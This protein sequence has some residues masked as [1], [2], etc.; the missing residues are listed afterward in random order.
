MGDSDGSV[1]V[2]HGT[3][4]KIVIKF[5]A[6]RNLALSHSFA[7]MGVLSNEEEIVIPV[8]VFR[9]NADMAPVAVPPASHTIHDARL[10]TSVAAPQKSKTTPTTE[11]NSHL[12]YGAYQVPGILVD[13][14]IKVPVT[15]QF[16]NLAN[17]QV[18]NAEMLPD[19]EED[20]EDARLERE[21]EKQETHKTYV[22]AEVVDSAKWCGVARKVWIILLIV[23]VVIVGIVVGITMPPKSPDPTMSPT[24][25]PT[26]TPTMVPMSEVLFRK[27]EPQIIRNDADRSQ[28]EDSTTPQA[29]A[30][31][32]LSTDPYSLSKNRATSEIL[33]RYVLVLLYYSTNGPN[34][35]LEDL[36][37]REESPVCDWNNRMNYPG[38]VDAR[39]I[40]CTRN[41]TV[42]R[43]RLNSVGLTGT[44][45]WELS[46]LGDLVDLVLSSN[47]LRESLPSDF[48]NLSNLKIFSTWG[49]SLTGSLPINLP[50]SLEFLEFSLNSMG[51]TIPSE[52]GN[53]LINLTSLGFF[54]NDLGGPIPSELGLL[55]AMEYLSTFDNK[56]TG[57]LPSELGK[58]TRLRVLHVDT[59]GFTGSLPSELGQLTAL[60][61]LHILDNGFKGVVPSE[62]GLLTNLVEFL[63]SNN[64]LIGSIPTE[65]AQLQKLENFTF[66]GNFLTGSVDSL[67][68]TSTNQLTVLNGDCLP[69]GDGSVEIECSCCTI[70]CDSNLECV[71]TP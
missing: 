20:V 50:S 10:A 7:T 69:N 17:P 23:M 66:Y 70:C 4:T 59:N 67:L 31:E 60:E 14:D 43:I 29:R 63:A 56:F 15:D 55:T 47:A 2:R 53:N 46:L 12:S 39:G 28:F 54:E 58:M 49:N 36:S 16:P 64:E 6:S 33:E 57:V 34:W 25:S 41:S 65:F 51:G 13:N 42:E 26:S 5:I 71:S 1:K 40:Y 61:Y 45:P 3:C 19:V 52:W 38:D 37:F 8:A 44:I 18:V 32:W 27:L 24:S 62:L 11:K 30:L 9:P 21:K 48:S 22:V 35:T 68:C